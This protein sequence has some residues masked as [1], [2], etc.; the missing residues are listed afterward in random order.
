MKVGIPPAGHGE[1]VA[2]EVERPAAA[3]PG[4]THPTKR[5][6]PAGI[7]HRVLGEHPNP[8]FLRPLGE[9]STG[10]RPH[11]HD[12]RHLDLRRGEIERR[13]PRAVVVGVHHRA[14]PRRHPVSVDVGGG[15]ARKHDPRPV[16]VLEHRGSFGCPRRQHHSRGTDPPQTLARTAAPV[17]S[18]VVGPPLQSG[19]EAVVVVPER[20]G[21][22]EHRDLPLFPQGGG[23]VRDPGEGGL[24]AELAAGAEQRAPELRLIVGEDHPRA[25]PR[26]RERGGKSGWT[27]P[28][29]EYVAECVALVVAVRIRTVR[30]PPVPR[31]SPDRPLVHG[32]GGARPHEGLVVEPGGEQPAKPSQ[33]AREIEAKRGP[34]VHRARLEPLDQLH[35]RPRRVG[36]RR[37]L[38]PG[39]MHGEDPV[40]LLRPRPDEASGAV[41]LDAA[42]HRPHSV[43]E[44]GGSEGVA[45]VALEAKPVEAEIHPPAAVDPASADEPERLRNAH[46]TV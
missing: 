40:R 44:E 5:V 29:H 22:G 33:S 28:H 9:G 45:P 31:H 39:V 14:P 13:P 46:S 26:R 35:H 32:P 21:P 20:G 34:A 4:G 6:A 12:G 18:N 27:A 3:K 11:V 2:V 36:N 43:G 24:A 42:R 1:K 17:R 37:A 23:A 7:D 10:P 8:E 38:H 41:V 16:V 30:R 19:D 15:R 25:R